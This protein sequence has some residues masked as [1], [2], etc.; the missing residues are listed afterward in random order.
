MENRI[1]NA[2]ALKKLTT[3]AQAALLIKDGMVVGTSGFT[4]AGYPKAVPLA[5]A[6]RAEA[7]EELKITLI[8]GA[9]VGDELDGSLARAGVIAR[10]YPYQTNNSL[11]KSINLG[12]VAYVDM[13]L[14]RVAKAIRQNMFGRIDIAII[15]A[16]AISE[17]GYIYPSSS[18]GCSNAIID[19][20]EKVIIEINTTQPLGLMGYHDVY[21]LKKAPNTESIPIFKASD[22]IGLPYFICPPEKIAAVVL[23]DIPDNT[24]SVPPLDDGSRKIAAFLLDFLKSQVQIG[25]LTDPLPPLQSGVGAVANAVLQGLLES[26]LDRIHLYSEVLQD[27][28]LDLIDAGKVDFASGTAFTFSPEKLPYFKENLENYRDTMILRTM[29]ISNSPEVISRL[30]VISVNTALEVDLSGNVNSTHVNGTYVMNGI[31]G[32]G[33]FTRNAAISVFTT[34]STA[35]EG[36]ISCIVPVVSHVD[37]TEHDVGIVITEQGLADLRGL[38]AYER[39]HELIE[40]CAHPKFRDELR[41]F[42]L[43]ARK[44]NQAL[45]GLV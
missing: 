2:V 8:T 5:L 26:D 28:V 9:S 3:A 22:R 1:K 10:R 7:G 12:E 33:D 27:A 41:N 44:N 39:A 23:C 40:N 37:H 30:G 6:K 45:H 13:H 32:S 36:L 21:G 31:G 20:A 24:R 18:L 43:E 15:E 25:C 14:S 29:E 19:A 17:E 35:K 16:I 42:V 38:T 11:R 4:M 34:M